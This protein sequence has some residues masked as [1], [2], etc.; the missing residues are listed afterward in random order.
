MYGCMGVW[1]YGVRSK[2][3]A[4]SILPK[5]PKIPKIQT[6]TLPTDYS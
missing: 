2:G 6:P 3:E 1:V 5:I 4:G